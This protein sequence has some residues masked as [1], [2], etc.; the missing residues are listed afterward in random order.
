MFPFDFQDTLDEITKLR[1]ELRQ[2]HEMYAVAQ[3][4]TLDASRKVHQ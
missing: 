1:D 2:A 4:E 3:V